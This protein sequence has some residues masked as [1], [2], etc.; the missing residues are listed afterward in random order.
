MLIQVDVR[1]T[2]VGAHRCA[3]DL[4]VDPTHGRI[5][6]AAQPEY[7][8]ET[9]AFPS[10]STGAYGFPVR[11]ASEIAVNEIDRFLSVHGGL[12]RVI[13]VAYS[14]DTFETYAESAR[15]VLD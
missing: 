6:L 9:V 1:N 5:A 12:D 14:P 7:A 15:G 10:I 13:M 4:D 11:L 8:I 3:P 2:F